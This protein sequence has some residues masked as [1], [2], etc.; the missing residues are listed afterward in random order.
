LE[1]EGWAGH[2]YIYWVILCV[3]EARGGAFRERWRV[4]VMM[5]MMMMMFRWV[6]ELG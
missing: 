6:V 5:M 3:Q 2:G 4:K 1:I